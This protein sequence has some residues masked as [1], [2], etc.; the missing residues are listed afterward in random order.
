MIQLLVMRF[1]YQNCQ[2]HWD[3]AVLF[4]PLILALQLTTTKKMTKMTK[5]TKM[6][7]M[8][9]MMKMMKM[10]KMMK[11]MTMSVRC[12]P[13]PLTML[14]YMALRTQLTMTKHHLKETNQ[15]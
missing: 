14:Q 13:H 3:V 11:M 7:K 6:K 9:K 10:K 4:V 8:M 15:R 1:P 5:M 12:H 2:I